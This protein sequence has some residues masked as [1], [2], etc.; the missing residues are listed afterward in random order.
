MSH[1]TL[2]EFL[3]EKEIK[4]LHTVYT[5]AQGTPHKAIMAW[6]NAR[7]ELLKKLEKRELLPDYFGYAVEY[8]FSR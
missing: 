5:Q 3:T 4:E 7:P 1:F 8:V 6:I 2:Q